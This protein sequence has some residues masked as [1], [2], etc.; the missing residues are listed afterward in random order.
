MLFAL[1]FSPQAAGLLRDGLIT[2]DRWKCPDWPDLVAQ[3]ATQLPVYVHFDLQAAKGTMAATR[4]DTITT[5]LEKTDTR[6]VNLHL[7]PTLDNFPGIPLDTTD[8]AHVQEVT[9][10]LISDIL[11]AV[12]RF[13]AERV[14][15]E[16]LIYRPPNGRILRPAVEPDVI[17]RV[18]AE[19]G[20]GFLLDISHARISARS[21]GMD[22]QTY[23]TLLPVDRLRELHVTGMSHINGEIHD[24]LPM[25]NADWPMLDWALARIASG[26]WAEP[27]VV[28]FEYGGI[29]PQ[30]AWR[31]DASVIADQ[32]PRLYNLVHAVKI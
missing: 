9:E 25:T 7:H 13:G 27:W 28:S 16:N 17:N 11:Q 1:N 30:F 2:I 5:L 22:E 23:I 21:L 3:A 12:A 29:G 19:T 10:R 6:H 14:I 8:P 26:E 20:C 15:V 31:S 24:H 18:I 4:W 32:V